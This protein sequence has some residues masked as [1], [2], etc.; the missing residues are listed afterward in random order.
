MALGNHIM[1]CT[2]AMEIFYL[3]CLSHVKFKVTSCL[4]K[5]LSVLPLYNTYAVVPDKNLMHMLSNF[6]S[7]AERGEDEDVHKQEI[8]L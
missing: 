6:V 2:A 1:S 4:Y 5:T 7:C 8:F 3:P